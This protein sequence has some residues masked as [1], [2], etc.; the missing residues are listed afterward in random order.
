LYCKH[1]L[2]LSNSSGDSYSSTEYN[3]KGTLPSS[4][5][6]LGNPPYPGQTTSWGPNWVVLR[7]LELIQVGYLAT[8]DNESLV[9]VYDYAV[10]GAMVQD[11]DSQINTEFL[12][13]AGQKPSWTPWTGTNSK[14]CI[15]AQFFSNLVT[16]IGNNDVFREQYD[17]DSQL[18]IMF[19]SQAQLVSAGARDFVYINVVPFDRSS[20]GSTP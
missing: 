5:Q 10:S 4:S 18:T 19:Q 7:Y 1:V 17:L 12:P 14:F 15:P 13:Y 16:W 2:K 6:P 11:A 8:Q 9:L 3:I 20:D